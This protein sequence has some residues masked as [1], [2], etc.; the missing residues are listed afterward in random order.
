MELTG[1]LAGRV[2]I[3]TGASSGF[4]RAIVLRCVREGAKVVAADL[5]E[6][7][8]RTTV[9]LAAALGGECELYV[10]DIATED[11]ALGAAACAKARF[12][13]IDILVNNAGVA[14]GE[15]SESWNTLEKHWDRVIRINLKSIYL[16]SRACIP[17]MVEKRRGSII[18]IASIA[19]TRAVG[20]AA[21]SAAKGGILGYTHQVAAE[22]AARNVRVN[23]VSPGYMRTP[24]STGERMGLS[25]ADQEARLAEM[26]KLV[27]MQRM[28]GVD[29]IAAAVAYLASDDAAYVTGQ[30]IVVDGGFLVA[31]S[32]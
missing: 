9:E 22:L 4:G 6:A 1:R 29:D 23:A 27:P 16:N 24:M 32:R 30:E 5:D 21:Y 18:N 14:P 8:G 12:D 3:V 15:A 20:G 31:G 2:A 17:T 11:G 10:A 26:G 25:P 13:T 28:G 7:G 19:A